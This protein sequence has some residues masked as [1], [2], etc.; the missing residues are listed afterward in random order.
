LS[1]KEQLKSDKITVLGDAYLKSQ[2]KLNTLPDSVG[3]T[4]ALAMN[5]LTYLTKVEALQ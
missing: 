1:E 3:K 4:D 2:S 5:T